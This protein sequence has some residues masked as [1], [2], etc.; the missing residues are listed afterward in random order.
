VRAISRID[1]RE[2][3]SHEDRKECIDVFNI[4][5]SILRR[6]WAVVVWI[7]RIRC[8]RSDTSKEVQPGVELMQLDGRLAQRHASPIQQT[9]HISSRLVFTR[10]PPIALSSHLVA[11]AS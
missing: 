1:E 4:R 6:D 8:S 10:P 2:G 11:I 3:K 7:A 9:D 5:G